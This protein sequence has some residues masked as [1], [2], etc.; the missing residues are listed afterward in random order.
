MNKT[1]YGID[2]LIRLEDKIKQRL[3]TQKTVEDTKY[4][5]IKVN[6]DKG[7]N[8]GYI[9]T[10]TCKNI[11]YYIKTFSNDFRLDAKGKIDPCEPLAYKIME[12]KGFGPKVYFLIESGSSSGGVLKVYI[13]EI[14]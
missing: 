3:V 6:G 9:V 2:S 5:N 7:A 8:A 13:L 10:D 1:K 4:I 14:L 11:N 12:Y